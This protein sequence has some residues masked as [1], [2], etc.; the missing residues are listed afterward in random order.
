MEISWAKRRA[1]KKVNAGS[2]NAI[3]G[4]SAS[5]S[6]IEFDK[7]PGFLHQSLRQFQAQCLRPDS[8]PCTRKALTNFSTSLCFQIRARQAKLRVYGG[9]FREMCR[10]AYEY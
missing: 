9:S 10:S 3:L 5:G 6:W 4:D 8:N 2:C 7:R 1:Q